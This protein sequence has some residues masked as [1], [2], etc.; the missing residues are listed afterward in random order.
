[1]VTTVTCRMWRTPENGPL[2]YSLEFPLHTLWGERPGARILGEEQ[3]SPCRF[4]PKT[5]G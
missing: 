4:A 2:P 5:G 1:V 3:S